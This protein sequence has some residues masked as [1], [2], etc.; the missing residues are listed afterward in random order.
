[1]RAVIASACIAVKNKFKQSKPKS[2]SRSVA[3]GDS[4]SL[5][6]DDCKVSAVRQKHACRSVAANDRSKHRKSGF[7][8]KAKA[9]RSSVASDESDDDNDDDMNKRAAAYRKPAVR[10]SAGKCDKIK[11]PKSGIYVRN[12]A[13]KKVLKK[14]DRDDADV[15]RKMSAKSKRGSA[16]VRRR[17]SSFC[18]ESESEADDKTCEISKRR[19]FIKP[20]KFDGTVSSFATFKA[21]FENAAKFNKWTVDEQLAYLKASL[22]G[23]A[24]QCLWDQNPDSIDTL[25]KLWNLLANRFAGHNLTEKY[26]TELRNRRRQPDESLDALSQDIRLL[27]VD[28]RLARTVVDGA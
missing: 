14:S 4:D 28:S 13:G 17:E 24:A 16:N 15:N 27:I 7:R 6:D 1:M 25:D 21:Q 11:H 12:H 23:S 2:A 20:V 10:R 19:A 9:N 5:C 3:V 18:S 22:T 26:R 8:S